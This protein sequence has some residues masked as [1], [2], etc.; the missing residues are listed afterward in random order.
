M[1]GV[2]LGVE[3]QSYNDSDWARAS[4]RILRPFSWDAKERAFEIVDLE[5]KAGEPVILVCGPYAAADAAALNVD[6]EHEVG[7]PESKEFDGVIYRLA[8]HPAT[9]QEICRDAARLAGITKRVTPHVLRHSFATHLLERGSDTRAIQVMLGHA[10][11]D[12]TARYTSVTPQTIRQTASPL[13]SLTI[14]P[15]RK[16]GR[17]RKQVTPPIPD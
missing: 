15:K 13:D 6:P 9:V 4:V 5:L 8:G 11:I 2:T 10:R 7:F 17:P 16:P 12:T 1:N 14:E 3:V